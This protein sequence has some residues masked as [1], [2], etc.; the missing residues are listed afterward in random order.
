MSTAAPGRAKPVGMALPGLVIAVCM[1]GDTLLYAVLP[2]YHQEFGLSL[3]MVG[4]LLSLNRWI[5]LVANS[6]VAHFG[7]RIGPH[8]L[9]I[10]AALGSA[11]S[12]TIYGLIENPTAQIL[13]RVLWGISYASLN[14]ST[15]AYAVSDRTNAGKRV[16]AS[17]A[18]IGLVQA[19]SLVGGAWIVL[20]L[21]A[22]PVFLI[23][24]AVTLIALGAAIVL[25]RLPAEPA[26][27]KGFR[28]PVPHRLEV[29]GFVMGFAGDGVFLLTLAFLMKDSI[30]S[31]A[32]VM[33]T[34]LLLALRWLVEVSTG[35]IGGW[36]GDR[37]GAR[38]IAIANA[39]LLVSGFVLIALDHELLGALMIVTTRGMFNT[40]IPVLVIERGHGTVLSSQAS[41]STWR[42]FGAAVGPLTA[43]WLFLNVPQVPLYAALALVLGVSAYFCLVRR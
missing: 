18:A 4:V 35:P 21:G 9:M 11:L 34:A 10:A 38:R 31:V 43:P 13:A 42:D 24:G 30:T 36:I 16:G 5:R 12:T 23:F 25:P 40:L 26:A 29:W 14:L 2:L 20:E 3:A 19:L 39:A 27:K 32:P 1:I 37:F 33:A 15:L 22:R 7:E 8:A 41:Y 17:R 6:G 28:L